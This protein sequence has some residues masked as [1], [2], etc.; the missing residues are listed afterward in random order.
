MSDEPKPQREIKTAEDVIIAVSTPDMMASA[1]VHSVAIG[2]TQRQLIEDYDALF[3]VLLTT[4]I[5][6]VGLHALDPQ[7]GS[8]LNTARAGRDNLRERKAALDILAPPPEGS[9]ANGL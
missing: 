7:I 4:F 5:D 6:G 8:F 2:R 1:L 3:D 9:A